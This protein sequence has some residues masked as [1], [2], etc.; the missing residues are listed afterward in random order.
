M[1]A[2][3]IL[4]SNLM[5]Y[6]KCIGMDSIFISVHYSDVCFCDSTRTIVS[7]LHFDIHSVSF[8]LKYEVF[9]LA[10]LVNLALFSLLIH[11]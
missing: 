8:L 7:L 4:P 5:V 1:F 3:L 10:G 11:F 2:I 9:F 6:P